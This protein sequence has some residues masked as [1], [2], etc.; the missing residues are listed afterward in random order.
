MTSQ[1]FER[2]RSLYAFSWQIECP[3]TDM[4]TKSKHKILAL[5]L[6]LVLVFQITGCS[7]VSLEQPSASTE[8]ANET[9]Y[10]YHDKSDEDS[11]KIQQEFDDF[12]NS[13][14]CDLAKS[15]SLYLHLL[16]KNPEQYGITS[17]DSP[18]GT[19][20]LI[21]MQESSEKVSSLLQQL[22]SIPYTPL[23]SKQQF[24][25]NVLKDYLETETLC[26]GME[27]Y[28]QPLSETIGI[29]AQLP[30][31]LS[32]YPFDSKEDITNYFSLLKA[33]PELFKEIMEFE[34]QKS[35]A[36]L[37]LD[38]PSI[39]RIIESCQTATTTP[40]VNPLTETFEQRLNSIEGL[41]EEE[42]E[43]YLEQN[44]TALTTYWIPAYNTLIEELTSLK[45]NNSHSG[46]LCQFPDGTE[47][48]EYLVLSNSGTSYSMDELYKQIQIHL[49]SDLRSI[50]N[51]IAK[52]PEL[53]DQLESY[54]FSATEPESIL[55]NLRTQITADFPSTQNGLGNVTLK[56]VPK[57]LESSLSPAFFLIPRLDDFQNTVIYINQKSIQQSNPLYT[58]LAHEGI[59]GHLYQTL[60]F[61][62]KNPSPLLRLLS[63]SGYSEG[64]ATY[65]EYYSYSFDN[66]LNNELQNLLMHNSAAILGLYALLDFNINYHGWTLK[67]TREYLD[68]HYSITDPL[69][70]EDIFYTMV[71]C[72][73]NY[74]QY[75]TGYLEILDLKEQ[76]KDMLG[77]EFDLKEF[78][79]F[80]LD[81]APASFR[82]I[83]QYFPSWL[84]TQQA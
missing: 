63:C 41:T 61:L 8:Q 66:G 32:E 45:G 21:Q 40:A 34:R 67:D 7:L 9:D 47:Y 76:A 14:F 58:T 35:E 52:N 12:T 27:L 65:A 6:C 71:N 17:T 28:V 1:Y 37:G 30:I 29:Q 11:I 48:Y 57:A 10:Q 77:E 68:S 79:T 84:L 62:Q 13:I 55:N 31:L 56:Y 3:Q 75:Y 73:S 46:G 33:V 22:E 80:I 59:P 81:M 43:N 18:F 83:R 23:T 74:L 38:D 64:W 78:H 69:V 20:S 24:L 44:T 39:D 2:R 19:Y 60:Y 49:D 36:G 5:L 82:V 54:T 26:E 72:P 51:M 50:S 53:G 4:N 42:K 70:V 25:Y 16:L 15:S